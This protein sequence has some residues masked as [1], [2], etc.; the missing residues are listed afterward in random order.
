MRRN[1]GTT[2]LR[3]FLVPFVAL[4][5]VLGVAGGFF[6]LPG[7][8]TSAGTVAAATRAEQASDAIADEREEIEKLLAYNRSI[9]L[10]PEQHEVYRE[11]LDGLRA[12]CCDEYSAA[13]CC[14][15]CNM[16]RATWG[17]A[18]HLVADQ[19][20]GA[21]EVRSA[22]AN[23]F[24]TINPDGFTGD[25]CFTGGCSR[26]FAKNGCGGMSEDHLIF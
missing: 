19:E 10:T 22:V 11:A 16:A 8:S 9:E 23:W 12:P 5:V 18:K 17:L 7:R 26:S 20:L 14:C 2:G 6:L 15:E 3:R 21:S 13:T 25:A 4:V 24:A 1:R